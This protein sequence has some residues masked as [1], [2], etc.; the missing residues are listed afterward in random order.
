MHFQFELRGSRKL[1]RVWLATI[2]CNF[3][4]WRLGGFKGR[5]I[6]LESPQNAREYDRL[7]HSAQLA[8]ILDLVP[9][10]DNP[11]LFFIQTFKPVLAP[12]TH[13]H[14]KSKTILPAV[15]CHSHGRSL[16]HALTQLYQTLRTL[17][18][19]SDQDHSSHL[20]TT[21]VDPASSSASAL[22]GRYWPA[23]NGTIVPFSRF[24]SRYCEADY[25]PLQAGPTNHTHVAGFRCS[26]SS[27]E[28]C[29]TN[30]VAQSKGPH[31]RSASTPCLIRSRRAFKSFCS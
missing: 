6:C 18:F 15:I 20:I 7:L 9:Y 31:P 14:R 11:P 26:H 22:V 5:Y 17:V 19:Q 2:S 1:A 23:P 10:I 24:A 12:D 4:W 29:L 25:F 21:S 30:E 27:L 8:T 3:R 28:L 13:R 16:S